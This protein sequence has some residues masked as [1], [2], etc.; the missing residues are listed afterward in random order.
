M[1]KYKNY[2]FEDLIMENQNYKWTYKVAL[3]SYN[4]YRQIISLAYLNIVLLIINIF[5][6]CLWLFYFY[7]NKAYMSLFHCFIITVSLIL[8]VINF[9]I[10]KNNKNKFIESKIKLKNVESQIQTIKQE[11]NN[12]V[13]QNV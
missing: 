1:S 4:R 5:H 9:R 2:E 11:F 3:D 13:K 6:S 7:Y 12:K 10:I 8:I